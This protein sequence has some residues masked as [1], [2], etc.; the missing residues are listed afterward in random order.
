MNL[1]TFGLAIV[2]AAA[3]IVSGCASAPSS[4]PPSGGTA[5]AGGR[6]STPGPLT[7]GPEG[8]LMSALDHITTDGVRGLGWSVAS[9]GDGKTFVVTRPYIRG[10]D[11]SGGYNLGAAWVF[12][13]GNVND[14]AANFYDGNAVSMLWGGSS[15]MSSDGSLLV[16]GS[17]GLAANPENAIYGYLSRSGTWKTGG[18][19]TDDYP[20]TFVFAGTKSSS[21]GFS[22]AVSAKN[23]TVVAGA[24]TENG[25]GVVHYYLAPSGGWRVLKPADKVSTGSL[26]AGKPSTGAEFGHSVAI[27]RDDS[28]IAV[29]APGDLDGRGAV[30]VFYKPAKGGWLAVSTLLKVTLSDSRPGDRFGESI[31]ISADGSRIAVGADGRDGGAGALYCVK[32][33]WLADTCTTVRVSPSGAPKGMGLS[34]AISADGKTMAGSHYGTAKG[35]GVNVYRSASGEWTDAVDI[36]DLTPTTGAKDMLGGFMGFGLALTDDGSRLLMGVPGYKLGSGN[37]YW[38]DMPKK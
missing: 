23:S 2:V 15:A 30:Y 10:S 28:V 32:Y 17:P 3:L 8:V 13:G 7:R 24:P 19:P 27:S 34:V 4:P 6:T 21:F 38:M 18:K 29:G 16:I 11:K 20:T 37:Y 9:S 1:R 31:S 35:G 26:A 5:S 14:S 25:Y 33:D 12:E 36:D 22:V